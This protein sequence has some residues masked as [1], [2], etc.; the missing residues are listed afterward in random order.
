MV[1]LLPDLGRAQSRLCLGVREG[2]GRLV[3]VQLL[4][5]EWDLE[6]WQ[7]KKMMICE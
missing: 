7:R 3:P 4:P 2:R 5:R 1:K 6:E